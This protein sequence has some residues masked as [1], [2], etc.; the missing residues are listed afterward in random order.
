M[1]G[2]RG[3]IPCL[4]GERGDVGCLVVT[5]PRSGVRPPLAPPRHPWPIRRLTQ[6]RF[7]RAAQSFS[8][9]RRIAR[10][11]VGVQYLPYGGRVFYG[12]RTTSIRLFGPRPP[13]S[14]H[15]ACPSTFFAGQGFSRA[16]AG[17][18]F[19]ATVSMVWGITAHAHVNAHSPSFGENTKTAVARLIALTCV[20]SRNCLSRVGIIIKL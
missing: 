18:T 6:R 13:H 8:L 9:Q 16:P 20:S 1:L 7:R 14:Q 4:V 5:P 15:S 2:C 19:T 10:V 12:L 3:I 17:D 11:R